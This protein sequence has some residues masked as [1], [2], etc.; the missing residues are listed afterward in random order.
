M[1]KQQSN[2]SNHWI[3]SM[4][5]QIVSEKFSLKKSKF[6]KECMAHSLFCHPAILQFLKAAVSLEIRDWGFSAF[7]ANRERQQVTWPGPC[8]QVCGLRFTFVQ[9][10]HAPDP[11][12]S[13][14]YVWKEIRLF[15][16]LLL[17]DYRILFQKGNFE[18]NFSAKI[19]VSGWRKT[20][21]AAT[22]YHLRILS[23]KIMGRLVTW[24]R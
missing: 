19:E 11:N 8:R 22:S 13:Q 2:I 4:I 14:S 20:N 1:L 3:W 9:L 7:P 16:T 18:D 10:D 15:I 24:N 6:F 12:T 23:P 21:M 17:T 5:Y